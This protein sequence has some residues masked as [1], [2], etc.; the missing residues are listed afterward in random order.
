MS[1][2]D[3]ELIELIRKESRFYLNSVDLIAAFNAPSRSVRGYEDWGA[4]Q[5]RS[6][7]GLI[8]RKPYAGTRY[9]DAIESLAARRAC[10]LF[11]AEHCNVQSQSGSQANYAVYKAMLQPGDKILSMS[12]KS[13]GHLTHGL[14][15][16][17]IRDLYTVVH[18]TVDPETCLLDYDE[19]ARIAEA[20]KPRL[21]VAGYSAYPRAVDFSRF[22]D[23]G[24]ACGAH[25]MA[26]ISHIAGF[27]AAGL[28][29]NPCNYD[30][31]VTCSV[32]KTLR[33]TRGGFIL[34]R[35]EHAAAIDSGVFPG[36]QSSVGLAEIVTLAQVFRE[37]S[38]QAFRQ[39]MSRVLDYSQ[40]MASIFK[41]RGIPLVSDGTDTHM[42]ILNVGTLGLTGRIAEQRLESVG[43]LANRNLVP[44]DPRLPWEASGLRV[45]TNTVAARGYARDE[46][47][48]IAHL[49]SDALTSPHW[50]RDLISKLQSCVQELVGK[51]REGDTLSDLMLPFIVQK[52]DGHAQ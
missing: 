48:L 20:E 1:S 33:G 6:T 18:Y 46:I 38:S 15:Q 51:Q 16:N 11:G 43:I 17:V 26:D 9:F 28:H 44:F 3:K 8:G 24:N 27:V 36:Y 19:I 2:D 34:C 12:L 45:G 35:N 50:A 39:Y 47:E 5:F 30:I 14:A 21:I 22:R 49:I 52:D 40:L 25:V 7:E 31:L 10:E 23:I 32:K 13:G 41:Q 29:Q 42:V 4:A 37:A